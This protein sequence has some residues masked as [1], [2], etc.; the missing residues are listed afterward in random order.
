[1]KTNHIINLYCPVG[2]TGYGITSLNIFKSLIE[3]GV[4]VSLFPMGQNMELNNEYEK[5]IALDA[6][7]K[8]KL[9]DH[10]APCL[11]IWHQNDLALRIGDGDF[12][13]F[14]FFELDTLSEQDVHHINTCR[15]VFT[16][17]KWSKQILLNNKV[18]IPVVV[19][20]LAV[21]MNIF[22]PPNKIKVDN[23]SYIFFHI[24]KWEHRKSQDFLL[25]A[26]E[27]AFDTNDNVELWLAPHNM[28]LNEQEESAWLK[29]V[30]NN[31]LKHKIKIFKRFTTQYDLA[32]FIFYADCGVFLSRAEGW[33]NE[34]LECMAM[35]KPIIATNYSAH[36]EYLTKENS[37]MVNIDELEV[38]NDNKWFF[39][40]G[41][42]AK[43]SDKQLDQTV[44]YMRMVYYD[45][46]K[47]NKAGVDT[48]KLYSWSNT[49]S[50][51]HQ[52]LMTNG[53]YYAN[54][55]KKKRRR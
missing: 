54:P 42:W 26:F 48:A 19:A 9:F 24:G 35:N 13:S 25:S 21:D 8:S 29:L 47:S 17:S 32:E 3:L 2:K 14:P 22:K 31:K 28:F 49:S 36:T 39:G 46:I 41:K 5:S 43:L 53:S 16:A 23:G 1:M 12:Y 33:N 6:I 15:T 52:T 27:K 38:A 20:P 51:I 10:K 37:L 18:T 11:K 45:N 40:N 4:D 50:I 30:E 55:T 44:D 7:K 34:I